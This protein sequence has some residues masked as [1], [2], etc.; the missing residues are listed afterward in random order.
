MSDLSKNK[1]GTFV[2]GFN[3]KYVKNGNIVG[4]TWNFEAMPVISKIDIAYSKLDKIEPTSTII[5]KAEVVNNGSKIAQ[6]TVAFTKT[7]EIV[8]KWINTLTYTSGY[9]ISQGVSVSP[10]PFVEQSAELSSYSSKT[11]NFTFNQQLK[12]TFSTNQQML[13]LVPS[14]KR[15]TISSII[16]EQKVNVPYEATLYFE[17]RFTK[18]PIG[19]RKVN[20]NLEGVLTSSV[21]TVINESPIDNSDANTIS[22]D[23]PK[24]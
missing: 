4:M 8:N 15:V 2:S 18:E 7:Y 21:K 9:K 1:P 3:V 11:E 16:L 6:K 24:I 22:T 14:G 10:M 13:V 5:E 17:N 20:G 19:V 12:T 23:V